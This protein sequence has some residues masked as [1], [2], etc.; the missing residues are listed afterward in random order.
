MYGDM[1]VFFHTTLLLF[2]S[3]FTTL[4][5]KLCY[6]SIADSDIQLEKHSTGIEHSS[7]HQIRKSLVL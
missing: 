4:T 5:D 2:A 1:Y 3:F 6:Q 7:T